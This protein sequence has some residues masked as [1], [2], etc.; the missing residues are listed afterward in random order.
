MLGD[1]DR[2]EQLARDFHERHLHIRQMLDSR[3]LG[4]A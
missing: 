1:N 2:A 3:E 4:R